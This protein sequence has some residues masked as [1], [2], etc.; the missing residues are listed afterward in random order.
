MIILPSL[1]FRE[2]ASL[3]ILLCIW[4]CDG[5]P[6]STTREDPKQEAIS[7]Q[8]VPNSPAD[9]Q[10]DMVIAWDGDRHAGGMGW[11]TPGSNPVSLEHDPAVSGAVIC[12]DLRKPTTPWWSEWGWNWTGWR[13]PGTDT[14]GARQFRFRIRIE[15]ATQPGDLQVSLRS[16]RTA[17]YAAPPGVR[18]V[19]LRK[20]EPD[21]WDGRW[22][23]V[24]IPM[25]AILAGDQ[26]R[27][28]F[29]QIYEVYMGGGGSGY[30]LFL[31]DL[32]FER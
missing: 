7:K 13:Q 31:T 18:G 32:A 25:D 29:D 2:I 9:Q 20:Y 12:W 11:S 14:T 26:H 15:G 19:S 5:K 10:H 30:R 4:S 6:L 27:Q 22:H 3:T 17:R 24:R 23:L 28:D 21:C 8:A 1:G 16:A